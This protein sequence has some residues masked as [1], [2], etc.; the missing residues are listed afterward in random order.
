MGSAKVFCSSHCSLVSWLVGWLPSPLFHSHRPVMPMT[1]WSPR[2]GY[3]RTFWSGP[4]GK[5]GR[6]EQYPGPS[7]YKCD[8]SSSRS[9][10]EMD[11]ETLKLRRAGL[12]FV[13]DNSQ[14]FLRDYENSAKCILTKDTQFSTPTLSSYRPPFYLYS[15][16]PIGPR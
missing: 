10:N 16:L 5:F 3:D 6:I 12:K 2:N 9:G 13:Y 8:A 15:A 11:G 14:S 7:P 1:P 4:E